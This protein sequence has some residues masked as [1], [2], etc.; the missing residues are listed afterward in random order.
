MIDE[1]DRLRARR[2]ALEA[3]AR[4]LSSI[5]R[6]FEGEGF[7]E[8]DTPA[9]VRAP[10]Q[11]VHLDALASEDRWLVTS[12]EYAMKRLCGAGYERIVSIG[13]CWRAEERGPH[14]ESEFTMIE[15]YRAGAPLEK[16][17]ADCEELVGL[18]VQAAGSAPEGP[19]FASWSGAP[20]F[21]RATV[22]ELLAAHAGIDLR[23]DEPAS[24]LADKARA[25]GIALG[26][27]TAWD[28][29]F[30]QVWLDR[31]EPHFAAGTPLFVFDWPSPLG[32]LARPHPQDP[33]LVERFELYA[34]GLELA[35]AFGELTDPEEQRARVT[36]ESEARRARGKTTYPLDEALL[37]ALARMPPT[38]GVALG[39]DRLM[40]LVLGISAIRDVMPFASDEI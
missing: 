40:M 34:G 14:H 2:P 7:L 15:W 29:I 1:A 28:D 31:V 8:V 38:A 36:R 24:E 22:R 12:P 21:R 26:S 4:V 5:R 39:F 23:G 25:A 20:P 16:I 37:A 13:K 27:A 17:A 18:A 11:E 6:W 3:R 19:A 33:S 30:F 9:R 10:G 35:N 32:A